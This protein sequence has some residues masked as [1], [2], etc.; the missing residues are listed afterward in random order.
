MLSSD[1]EYPPS[2]P[3]H[4]SVN[5]P[6][7]DESQ[8]PLQSHEK[9]NNRDRVYRSRHRHDSGNGSDHHHHPIPHYDNVFHMA[10]AGGFRSYACPGAFIRMVHKIHWII[11]QLEKDKDKSVNDWGTGSGTDN[12]HRSLHDDEYSVVNIL[13]KEIAMQQRTRGDGDDDGLDNDRGHFSH[14]KI[15]DNMTLYRDIKL[16]PRDAATPSASSSSYHSCHT[17]YLKF[18]MFG[19]GHLREVMK[20]LINSYGLTKHIDIILPNGPSQ[21]GAHAHAW[22]GEQESDHFTDKLLPLRRLHEK[23]NCKRDGSMD[24]ELIKLFQQVDLLVDPC[25]NSAGNAYVYPL[26]Q[27]YHIPIVLYRTSA[28]IEWLVTMPHSSSEYEQMHRHRHRCTAPSQVQAAVPGSPGSKGRNSFNNNNNGTAVFSTGIL[29]NEISIRAMSWK[30]LQVALMPAFLTSDTSKSRSKRENT[31][32][33]SLLF[34]SFCCMFDMGSLAPV[35]YY[36]RSVF[37][38][39]VSLKWTERV[40]RL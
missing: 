31:D 25:S 4:A 8:H 37:Q 9:G 34:R 14:A 21:Q 12:D 2:E 15:I 20:S 29:V 35:A 16:F 10:F 27:L 17:L 18:T 7:E 3:K 26:A 36:S 40:C 24:S 5:D 22:K 13:F 39:R 28:S 19:D 6:H 1:D 23:K 38:V 33:S 30:M 32:S 11:L